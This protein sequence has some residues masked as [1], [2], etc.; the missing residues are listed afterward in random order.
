MKDGYGNE[1]FWSGAYWN[2]AL[3][4]WTVYTIYM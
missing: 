3:S 1:K 2:V 4:T